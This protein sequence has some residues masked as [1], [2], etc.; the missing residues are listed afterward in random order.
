MH[1]EKS[2]PPR[3]VQPSGFHNAGAEYIEIDLRERPDRLLIKTAVW[4]QLFVGD[5]V[6]VAG[7]TLTLRSDGSA[8]F[9]CVTFTNHTHSGDHWWAGFLLQDKDGVTLH[10]EGYHEGPRMDD[11]NPPPRYRWSF[12]FNFNA[13]IFNAITKVYYSYKC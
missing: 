8:S 1:G 4:P 7:A 6:E 13:S 12:N 9:E 5:C 3:E 2:T 11:G 10:N